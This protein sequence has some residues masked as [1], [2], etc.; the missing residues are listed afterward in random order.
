M[1]KQPAAPKKAMWYKPG[2]PLLDSWRLEP[3]FFSPPPPSAPPGA[4]AGPPPPSTG[5]RSISEKRPNENGS[6]GSSGKPDDKNKQVAVFKP[7]DRVKSKSGKRAGTVSGLSPN[8]NPLVVWDPV[9]IAEAYTLIVREQAEE[10]DPNDLVFIE[11]PPSSKDDDESSGEGEDEGESDTESGSG[12]GSPL[13][14]KNKPKSSKASSKSEKDENGDDAGEDN[15]RDD[16]DADDGE[17]NDGEDGDED[18]DEDGGNKKEQTSSGETL[19]QL[20]RE[21]P[22]DETTKGGVTVVPSPEQERGEGQQVGET[23]DGDPGVLDPDDLNGMRQ[24]ALTED[25]LNNLME[26][27][28]E[29]IENGTASA[30]PEGSVIAKMMSSLTQT[31]TDWK[32]MLKKF[33]HKG[34]PKESLYRSFRVPG[35]SS[36]YLDTMRPSQQ[37]AGGVPTRAVVVAIDTSGSVFNPKFINRFLSEVFRLVKTQK[38][39]VYLVM[40]D[41]AVTAGPVHIT[42]QNAQQTLSTFKAAGGGGTRMSCVAEF[43]MQPQYKKIRSQCAGVVYITDCEL[44]GNESSGNVITLPKVPIAIFGP[45]SIFNTRVSQN[46]QAKLSGTMVGTYDDKKSGALGSVANDF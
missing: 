21:T 43:L 40:W 41:T 9:T 1:S 35:K 25:E 26:Q 6:G 8:G 17:D 37:Y 46:I 16:G 7:G 33:L 13:S 32:Q 12:G 42:P 24:A 3:V 18:G 10:V 45:K 38:I 39:E 34:K 15:D 27:V 5:Q 23:E 29:E 14:S 20:E 22:K 11:P 19:G 36:H 2:D 31:A 30:S 44:Y 4:P 28:N